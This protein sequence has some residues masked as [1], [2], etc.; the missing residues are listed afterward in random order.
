VQVVPQAPQLL[1]VFKLVQMPLQQPC[2]EVQQ[3][4]LQTWLLGQ[5]VPFTQVWP[6]V[7]LEAHLPF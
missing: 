3:T 6:E 5:H 1:V 2:P 7:Q 4:P